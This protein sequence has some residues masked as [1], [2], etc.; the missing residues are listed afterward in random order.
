MEVLRKG[1]KGTKEEALNI[2]KKLREELQLPLYVDDKTAVVDFH[3]ARSSIVFI[4]T[5]ETLTTVKNKELLEF[6]KKAGVKKVVLD[7]MYPNHID[8]MKALCEAGLE[9]EAVSRPT[10]QEEFRSFVRRKVEALKKA[11]VN[12]DIKLDK[13][14]Y[15]DAVITAFIYPKY[16]RIVDVRFLNC[17]PYMTQW[18]R[19]RKLHKEFRQ[20]MSATPPSIK[21]RLRQLLRAIIPMGRIRSL[22]KVDEMRL[23]AFATSFVESVMENYPEYKL[24]GLFERLRIVDNA[25]KQAFICEVF[26]EMLG[27][28]S[29]QK[30]F[31]KAGIRIAWSDK[32]FVY[33][34]ALSESLTQAATKVYHINPYKKRSLI[35]VKAIRLADEIFSWMKEAETKNVED[36]RV[37]ETRVTGPSREER[38]LICFSPIKGPCESRS[39]SRIPGARA[40][41]TRPY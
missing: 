14:D 16:R 33:D 26:I 30:F 39:G 32:T 17:W 12:I 28:K 13:S 2:Y 20:L 1:K 11:G 3:W 23:E 18:R 31:N 27:Y 34:R 21:E 4:P 15:N 40:S 41:H 6:L 38:E 9:V 29:R 8:L 24:M 25:I 10:A 5:K 36:G 37:E 22:S 35:K 7:S 19:I